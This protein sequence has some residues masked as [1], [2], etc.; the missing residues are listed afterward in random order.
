MS[1]HG[2]WSVIY[3][4]S[5][6]SEHVWRSVIYVISVCASCPWSLRFSCFCH[7]MCD[8]VLL[9]WLQIWSYKVPVAVLG[10]KYLIC[11]HSWQS[12]TNIGMFNLSQV[13]VFRISVHRVANNGRS[14]LEY[15]LYQF[16]ITLCDVCQTRSF[17]V[18][19]ACVR[20]EVQLVLIRCC[21]VVCCERER[22]V[23]LIV[24]VI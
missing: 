17:S 14:Q 18:K 2:R 19:S 6:G 1:E 7:C 11:V 24:E 3:V 12:V 22:K 15:R 16:T 10:C 21:V 23:R 4:L 8:A 13:C 20:W 5:W 9:M